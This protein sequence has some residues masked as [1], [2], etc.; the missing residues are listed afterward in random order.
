NQFTN[1]LTRN[2]TLRSTVEPISGFRIELNASRSR[3]QNHSEYFRYFKTTAG[4]EGFNSFSALDA[5]NFS[6]SWLTINTAFTKD[7]K[8][9]TSEVFNKFNLNRQVISRRLA[10]QN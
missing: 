2:L 10:S 3:A 4:E 8:D 6:I 5:G 7:K 9:Y 1:T